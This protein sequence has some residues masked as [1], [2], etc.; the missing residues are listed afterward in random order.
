[1]TLLEETLSEITDLNQEKMQEIR[2]RLDT[3]TKPPGSLGKLEDL[4]TQLAGIQGELYPQVAE[5][6]HIL[7]AGDHGVVEE[8]VSA[9]PQ[10]ITAQMVENFLEGGAAINVLCNQAAVDLKVVDIGVAENIDKEGLI[11]KK[12][13]PGTANLAKGPAMSRTEAITSIEVGIEV[14]EDRCKDG[15]DLVSIG[16]MGIG[17]TTPSS[18]ILYAMSDC[19]LDDIV[20]YGSGISEK[21]RK[22]KKKVIRRAME[23]NAPEPDDGLDVLAKVGG[24]EIGGMAGVIIAAAAN[25]VPVVIDG[26]IAGAALM[27]AYSLEPKVSKYIISSHKSVE[28]GHEKIYNFLELEPMLQMNM[29]LGEGTG[30]VLAM[31]LVEAA[32]K[33]NREM[34][35]FAD[36]N[37][38]LG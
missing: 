7:L 3:L 17:N 10:S 29:R 12:I 34:A 30:A 24:L 38:D 2:E 19:K 26:F 5:K 27:I 6:S 22:N 28:P 4:A 35:T 8:G 37:M 21:K 20:G 18:A 25:S 1:M 16:E 33:I 15:L 32:T 9:V 23:I 13:R 11:K 14:F 31:N 36:L